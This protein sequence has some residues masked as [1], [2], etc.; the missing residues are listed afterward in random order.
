M[1]L[2]NAIFK[3]HCDNIG[4]TVKKKEEIKNANTI[5]LMCMLLE[6][7]QNDIEKISNLSTKKELSRVVECMNKFMSE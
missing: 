7:P 5:E 1:D 2:R 3:Y 4:M 6:I